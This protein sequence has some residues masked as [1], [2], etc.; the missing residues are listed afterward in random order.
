MSH[1]DDGQVG[2]TIFR[3]QAIECYRRGRAETVLPQ[4]VS[5]RTFRYLWLL[6]VL[7][8]TVGASGAVLP[9]VPS[10]ATGVAI[11]IDPSGHSEPVGNDILLAVFVAPEHVSRLKVGQTLLLSD[12]TGVRFGTAITDVEPGVISPETARSR[13]RLDPGAALT[14]T[15][16]STVA[17][18]RLHP[19]YKG[20]AAL[21]Y[22]GSIYRAD[23]TIGTRRV[24]SFLPLIDRLPGRGL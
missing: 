4:V 2:R 20:V 18:T 5:P 16:P 22:T 17:I 15:Q 10:Y 19:P 14:V 11:A 6:L 12:A 3:A 1:R 7:L 23:I 21:G 9:R 8:T 13:F 24:V